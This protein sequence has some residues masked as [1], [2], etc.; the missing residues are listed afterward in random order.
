MI[1]KFHSQLASTQNYQT[2]QHQVLLRYRKDMT[3]S[4]LKGLHE[5][6]C[7]HCALHSW[8]EFI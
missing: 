7:C 8:D 5:I 1:P 2:H 3:C 6:V 4:E